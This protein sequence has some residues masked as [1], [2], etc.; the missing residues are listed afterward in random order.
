MSCLMFALLFVFSMV[1]CCVAIDYTNCVTSGSEISVNRFPLKNP[2]L[3]QK[4][5]QAVKRQNLVPNKCSYICSKHF[6]L[7]C[8]VVRPGKKDCHLYDHA[9]PTL[10]QTFSQ[11]YQKVP[12]VKKFSAKRKALGNSASSS[13]VSKS[14]SN[15][16][17][18]VSL[19][20]PEQ[21]HSKHRRK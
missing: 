4:W 12:K 17:S 8:F 13:K 7:S 2:E 19:H 10:F 16:H 21:K 9:V 14:F 11:N 20:G 5:I 1:N 3:L 15:D 18:Y 6:E